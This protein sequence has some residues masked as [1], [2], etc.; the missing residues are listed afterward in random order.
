MFSVK[1]GAPLPLGARIVA[2]GVNFAV[3]SRH[4]EAMILSVY[5][6]PQDGEPVLELAEA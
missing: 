4:A 2:E 5:A 1:P 3:F 6:T